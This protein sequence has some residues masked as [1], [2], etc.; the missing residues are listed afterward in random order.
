MIGESPERFREEEE[1]LSHLW[2]ANTSQ[3]IDE[4]FEKNASPEYLQ[5]LKEEDERLDALEAQGILV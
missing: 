2:C 5:Y 3:D 4:F 1:H